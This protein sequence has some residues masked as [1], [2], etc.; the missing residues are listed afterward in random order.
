[1]IFRHD[2]HDNDVDDVTQIKVS[3]QSKANNEQSVLYSTCKMVLM[4]PVDVPRSFLLRYMMYTTAR[5]NPMKNTANNTPSAI[6]AERELST[7][8]T[9]THLISHTTYSTT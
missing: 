8:V 2:E 5:M 1:M 6:T 4:R 7:S 3:V 9:E